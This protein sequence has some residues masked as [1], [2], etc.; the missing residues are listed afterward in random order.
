MPIKLDKTTKERLW[1]LLLRPIPFLPGPE[2]YDL[3]R[4]ISKSQ[5]AFD[6]QVA[7]AVEALH[8]TS[9]LVA[10]LQQGVEEKMS[11]L[12]QLQQEHEKYSELAQIEA[13]KA[14]ALLKQVETT[15][16]KEQKKERWIAL[17]MHLGA[18]LL[19]FILGVAV[20]D[21]FKQWID[22]LWG[23]LLH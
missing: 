12:K 3:W 18:G 21:S 10:T 5:S 8:N 7:E 11:K 13:K 6:K 2:I 15:L 22:R 1:R 16:G 14:E 17:A 23:K 20:S 4:A 9:S 19:F